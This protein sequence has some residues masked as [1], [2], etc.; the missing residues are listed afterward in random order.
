MPLKER[1]FGFL[2]K[3]EK[4]LTL[5]D[6]GMVHPVLGKPQVFVVESQEGRGHYLVDLEAES[7]TCPAWT[8]GKTR[9][10]KHLLAAVVHL[11]R[12]GQGRRE[13]A[14]PGERPVA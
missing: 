9:P 4:A 12:K 11:W 2:G 13:E 5:V 6:A 10:C 7:C 1:M 8:S 3:L 14:Q